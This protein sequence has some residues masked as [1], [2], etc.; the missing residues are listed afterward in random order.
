MSYLNFD[1]KL[2]INLERSLSKEMIRTNRA[3]AYNSTTLV[4]CNTRKYHG[5]LVLPLGAPLPEGNYV[6]LGSLDETVIQHG[7]EFNLGLHQYDENIYMPN[8]HKYIREFDCEVI[9]K[10]TYRVGGVVL[11]KERMLVSF[12]PRVLIRYTLVEA[13]SP[14]TLRLKPF[15]AYRNTNESTNET[16][17]A[18]SEMRAGD[19]SRLAGT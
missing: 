10:T 18:N 1:K 16:D 19:S 12:E 7:A 17:T 9:S 3:G 6:L 14:T 2:L 8:G 13:H 11:T 4:D 15:L 5:Q